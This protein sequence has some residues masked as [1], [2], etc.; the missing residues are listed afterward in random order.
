VTIPL[1]VLMGQL[2]FHTGLATDLYD[3]IRKWVGRVPGGL[4]HYLSPLGPG[5]AHR[6][7]SLGTPRVAP[8]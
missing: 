5:R 7:E 8:G 4:A 6:W 1:F 3:G 2:V